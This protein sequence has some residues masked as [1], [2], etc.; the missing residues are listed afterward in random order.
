[1]TTRFI[2]LLSL[3]TTVCITLKAQSPGGVSAGLR[4]W[5]K[6]N[7]AA[8]SASADNTSVATWTDR[9]GNSYNL[10]QAT[11]GNQPKYRTN[12]V[13]LIN[14][15]PSLVFTYANNQYLGNT[16]S[17]VG[18]GGT[19]YHVFTVA[20][21]TVASLTNRRGIFNIGAGNGSPSIELEKDGNAG[22][23]FNPFVSLGTATGESNTPA[24]NVIGAA[25]VYNGGGVLRYTTTNI[26]ASLTANI[27]NRQAQIYGL[28][29]NGTSTLNCY[30]DGYTFGND[31]SA[32]PAAYQANGFLLGTGYGTGSVTWDGMINEVIAYN[33]EL[34]GTNLVKVQSYLALKYGVTLGQGNNTGTTTAGVWNVGNNAA[35]INY[36]YSDA[37]TAF[38]ASAGTAGSYLYDIAAMVRDDGSALI[39]KQS[40]SV[41]YGS[42]VTL[43]LGSISASN[44]SNTGTISTDKSAF[45]WSANIGGFG[46]MVANAGYIAGV[47]G[48]N[49]ILSKRWKVQLTGAGFT[50]KTIRVAI[51]VNN[52]IVSAG[53]KLIVSTTGAFNN[54]NE[55]KYNLTAGG[56]YLYADVPVSVLAN[57]TY[58]T[59]GD[60]TKSPGGV[61]S[62]LAAWF[63]A[64]AGVNTTIGGIAATDGGNAAQW[65]NQ[66]PNA[67]MYEVNNTGT[68]N[69]TGGGGTVTAPLYNSSTKLINY[70]PSIVFSGSNG[71][72]LY[73]YN[74][75]YPLAS[76]GN[77]PGF[78]LLAV[79]R[80]EASITGLR[81]LMGNGLNGNYPALDLNQ[82]GASP[83]G[84]NFLSCVEWNGGGATVYNGGGIGAG[85]VAN[86]PIGYTSQINNQQPQIFG[87][88]ITGLTNS[89]GPAMDVWVDGNKRITSAALAGN[90]TLTLSTSGNTA[91]NGV[92]SKGFYI[93]SSNDA[94]WTGT[95]NEVLAYSDKVTDADMQKINT[96]LAIK[97]GITL[98]QGNNTA[99]TAGN[100]HISDNFAKYDYVATDGTTKIWDATALNTYRY[101]IAGI[102]RDDNEGLAQKQSTSVNYN[103]NN[104][105]TI[106]LGGIF[107]SNAA[108]TANS[109]TNDRSYL[110]WGDN[111]QATTLFAD[112]GTPASTPTF[113][114]NS[115]NAISTAS[116]ATMTGNFRMKRTWAVSSTNFT[117]LVQIA[118][119]QTTLGSLTV[120]GATAP[121]GNNLGCQKLCLVTASDAA[122][123]TNVKVTILNAAT[124]NGVASYTAST[125]FAAGVSYFSFGRVEENPEGN[126]YLPPSAGTVDYTYAQKYSLCKED[127]WYYYFVDGTQGQNDGTKK[128]YAIHPNG[129]ASFNPANFVA[130]SSVNTTQ[131][132][133]EV[134]N[135]SRTTRVMGRMLTIVDASATATYTPALKVRFFIDSAEVEATKLENMVSAKW[136]KHPG[137]RNSTLA[138]QDFNTVKNSVLWTITPTSGSVD[139]IDYVQYDSVASFSTFGFASNS[140]LNAI[141]LPVKLYNFTVVKTGSASS[142]RW[143]A[144]IE[145]NVAAYE[146][147][148]SNDGNSFT[149][150]GTVAATNAGTYFF[151]DHQPAKGV[152]YYYI[153][154][155][156]ISGAYAYSVTRFVKFDDGSHTDAVVYPNPAGKGEA[157]T[158]ALSGY[159][160]GASGIVYNGLGQ[161]LYTGAFI[162]GSNILPTGNLPAGIYMLKIT[163]ALSGDA[164][165]KKIRIK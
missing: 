61:G 121:A 122:F 58:F 72:G 48:M 156:D 91:D 141:P 77:A 130:G 43:G 14:F 123:T 8:F 13:N 79:G 34:S 134:T 165:I 29:Q 63:K 62:N 107:A 135:G 128:I 124:V 137:D 60:L 27:N 49:A 144:G 119:P 4:I 30:I 116:T 33:T 142:L 59:Y 84:I 85:I 69:G 133:Y 87:A 17:L 55:T 40:Q 161:V 125:K 126:I 44:A 31:R 11:A 115:Y 2:F 111:G 3:L 113:T 118:I 47:D 5:V 148:R 9:S 52:G 75:V 21:S 56:G 70:N 16:G 25:T 71:Y 103:A 50:G 162:N 1:M 136:F 6:A 86:T 24:S 106:G 82:D 147:Y 112:M 32:S 131:D 160:S 35:R 159:R 129:N 120:N 37:S 143:Q 22:N 151:T 41:N 94:P 92:N 26:P 83:N 101:H 81:A 114:Y 10:T 73:N 28:S 15:N 89:C 104:Q 80:E 108:N 163:D 54:A 139:G 110:V 138:D 93:G 65:L 20:K 97:Y 36:L 155:V 74:A 102:G 23:A 57:G 146:V 51:P 157:V 117:Q 149:K 154:T 7:D 150:I 42:M 18:T 88:S 78:H 76:A 95:I 153:K 164:I 127:G 64:D 66:V 132:P 99:N 38:D 90:T 145:T 46:S 140:G 68:N 45:M 100:F 158:V 152:N 39:Q 105:V 12:T 98:G 53:A 67:P 96:Y 19:G 109:F